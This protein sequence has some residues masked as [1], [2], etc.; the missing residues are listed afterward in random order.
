MGSKRAEQKIR[1]LPDEVNARI[2]AMKRE[3]MNLKEKAASLTEDTDA[4]QKEQL[5]QEAATAIADYEAFV[6]EEERKA[7]LAAPKAQS[8]EICGTAYTG[9]DEYK[10]HLEYR[11]HTVYQQM[12]EKLEELKSRKEERDKA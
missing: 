9:D 11:V 8:C 2:S 7:A 4:R 6:K 3:A 5:E 10:M 12:K 1:R